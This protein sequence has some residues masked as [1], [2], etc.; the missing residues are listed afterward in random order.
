[1]AI[2]QLLIF[3]NYSLFVPIIYVITFLNLRLEEQD[4]YGLLESYSTEGGHSTHQVCTNHNPIQAL[5]S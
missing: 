1:M 3:V 2:D 4:N 5:S